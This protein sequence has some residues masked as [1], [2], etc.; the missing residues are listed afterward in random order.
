MICQ[1]CGRTDDTRM[2]FCFECATAGEERAARRT[3]LQ[4]VMKGLGHC[5]RGYWLDARID[6]S[7]AWERLTRTGDYRPGG[8]FE[9]QYGVLTN[10][11][12]SF[13]G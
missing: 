1:G 5:A 9:S 7:W 13:H 12:K 8:E 6:F 10:K 3:V 4:H 11:G 2:G